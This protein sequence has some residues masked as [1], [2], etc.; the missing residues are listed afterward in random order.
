VVL[1]GVNHLFQET[2]TGLPAEYVQAR[3]PLSQDALG[4]IAQR[5]AALAV[6]VCGN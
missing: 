5:T 2:E 4:A 3:H 1:D 6:E